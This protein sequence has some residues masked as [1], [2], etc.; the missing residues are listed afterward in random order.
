MNEGAGRVHRAGRPSTNHD[1]SVRA[2]R[3]AQRRLSAAQ[4]RVKHLGGADQKRWRAALD[5]LHQ[6]EREVAAERGEQHAI[7]IDV[8]EA[9]DVGAPM[10][11]LLA[12]PGSAFIVCY[13]RDVDPGWDG[14]YV[15]MRSPADEDASPLLVIEISRCCDVRMG[16]PN[17]EAI[18]GHPLHG[19]GLSGY[20]AHEVVNSEWLEHVIRLQLGPPAPLGGTVP[21]TASLPAAVPRRDGR[22]PWSVDP[23]HPRPRHHPRCPRRPG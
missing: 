7:V 3:T 2:S 17:D 14:T 10:P 21:V 6:A 13:A 11:H 4:D 22:S 20:E 18:N 1:V 16:G 15:T 8:G 23:G 12:G 9:W 5:E 19:R